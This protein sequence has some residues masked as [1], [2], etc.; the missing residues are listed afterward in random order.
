VAD[1]NVNVLVNVRVRVDAAQ[2]SALGSQVNQVAG[3]L[4]QLAA[5]VSASVP[6]TALA[7][8]LPQQI[9]AAPIANAL[10]IGPAAPP[11]LRPAAAFAP[12]AVTPIPA[13]PNPPS[14]PP[15]RPRW[16]CGRTPASQRASARRWW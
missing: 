4:R 16:K 7:N 3:S 5:P 14:L 11:E 13:A 10:P 9:P 1:R 2:V 12:P 8:V 15:R 6:R